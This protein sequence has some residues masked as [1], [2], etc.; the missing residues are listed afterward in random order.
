MDDDEVG[1][2][3]VFLQTSYIFVAIDT[4]AKLNIFSDWNRPFMSIE[5][6]KDPTTTTSSSES[7]HEKQKIRNAQSYCQ[8]SV[9]DLARSKVK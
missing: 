7:N 4:C 2:C 6:E 3:A 1:I 8:R 5:M 9:I